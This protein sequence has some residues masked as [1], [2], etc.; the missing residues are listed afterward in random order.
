MK[1]ATTITICFLAFISFA[2][3]PT[4]G[5]LVHYPFAGDAV[6]QSEN[7]YD[8]VVNGAELTEDRFSLEGNAYDFD[9]MADYI[10]V[11][12]EDEIKPDF[13]LIH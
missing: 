11:P 7:S 12:N 8:G 1:L 3:V 4:E 5:L 6:D 13:P 10:V 9:G 2:Q